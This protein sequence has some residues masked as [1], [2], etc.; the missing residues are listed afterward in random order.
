[1]F[2]TESKEKVKVRSRA[3]R[4]AFVPSLSPLSTCAAAPGNYGPDCQPECGLGQCASP[5]EIVGV[6][7]LWG[8]GDQSTGPSIS[9][10][11]D[12]NPPFVVY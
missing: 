9:E 10:D 5:P 11:I 2:K 4:A 12:E 1:M 7:Q 8:G 6:Y 3:Q